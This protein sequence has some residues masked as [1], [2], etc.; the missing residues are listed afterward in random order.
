VDLVV[1]N[2]G[3]PPRVFRNNAE[4]SNNH[5]LAVRV[6]VHGRD[7][8]GARVTLTSGDKRLV[9]LMTPAYSYLSSSEPRAHFGLGSNSEVDTIE[10]V[11]ADGTK[12]LFKVDAVD[13]QLIIRKGD[14]NAP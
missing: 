2:I 10:V 13:Q 7:A 6:L 4:T 9:R 11:W 8:I 1:G 5:W 12:E 3:G 14:G